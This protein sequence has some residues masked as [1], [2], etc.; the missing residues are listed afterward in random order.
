M[1][2]FGAENRFRRTWVEGSSFAV[3]R[4]RRATWREAVPRA[5]TSAPRSCRRLARMDF[6]MVL[7]CNTRGEVCCE[8]R[9]VDAFQSCCCGEGKEPCSQYLSFHVLPSSW[10]S[11]VRLYFRE[12]VSQGMCPP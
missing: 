9:V 7:Q 12:P 8:T 11:W 5:V 10:A 3:L 6:C 2:T 1:R 4:T